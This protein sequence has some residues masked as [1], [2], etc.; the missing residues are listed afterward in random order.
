[1]IRIVLDLTE[2]RRNTE[3]NHGEAVSLFDT[4]R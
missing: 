1:M 4:T 2:E 3:L